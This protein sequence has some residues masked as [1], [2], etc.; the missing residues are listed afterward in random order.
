MI[1]SNV[2]KK[3]FPVLSRKFHG[4]EII[5]L[6]SAA[7]SQKPR[8]VIEAMSNYYENYNSNVHRGIYQLS[9]ESTDIYEKTRE[10]V[11][12]FVSCSARETV[13]V[14]NT[15][16]ALNLLAYSLGHRLRRGDRILLTEM[17][18]HSNII[19]WQFLKSKGV[20]LDYVKMDADFNLDMED[21][22]EKLKKNPKIV[23]VTQC[24]NV[25]GTIN[26][27]KEMGS[28]AHE[29]GS[30]FIVD[31]AQSV[32][33]MPV[34]FRDLDCDFIAFSGHKMLGPMGI[35]CL[36]GKLEELKTMHPFL[37]GGDM[38]RE[39][40]Y[41]GA[42]W[43]DVPYKFEAGTPNVAGSVGLSAAVDYLR[44]LGMDRVM[45]HERLLIRETLKL[46]P[47]IEGLVSFG[48]SDPEKRGGVFSFNIGSMPAF[49]IER[50]LEA[51]NM[52]VSGSVH[53]HDVAASL[54]QQSIAI[55]SGHHCAMPL[56][57]RM[58]VAATSRASYYIYN[59]IEDVKNLFIALSDVKRLF[60]R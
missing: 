1:D 12:S 36:V 39:V 3:D 47:E 18:H 35:G 23:S 25:L 56:M 53:P 43:N 29:R 15:T 51:G 10:N 49:R 19:P 31:G 4:K 42:T 50:E 5:Y 28:L 27:V 7:T 26:P 41:E 2:I 20:E 9:E 55:R 59:S 38:I 44:N 37:G 11:A 58:D 33:H 54:D 34:S 40:S 52:V 16:E 46:A 32:P 30:V 57:G 6:D 21:Y 8:S 48:P 45:D 60:A 22:S 17:E 14:R 24:S 13:Y